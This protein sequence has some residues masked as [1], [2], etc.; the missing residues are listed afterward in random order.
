MTIVIQTKWMKLDNV[1]EIK[2]YLGMPFHSTPFCWH[3]YDGYTFTNS[4]PSFQHHYNHHPSSSSSQNKTNIKSTTMYLSQ[5]PP[6]VQNANLDVKN[7][8]CDDSSWLSPCHDDITMGVTQYMA[9]IFF[10]K[11]I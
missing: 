8:G 9:I 4:Y 1:D 7:Y 10:G 2:I 11:N 6:N 5:H 3:S